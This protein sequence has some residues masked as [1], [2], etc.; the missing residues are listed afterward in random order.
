MMTKMEMQYMDAVIQ[1]NRDNEI[2]RWTGSNVA[3]N[4]PRLH[5][6]WLQSFTM[7]VKK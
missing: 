2:T 4:W 1:I 6:L 7:I 3:M 5:C